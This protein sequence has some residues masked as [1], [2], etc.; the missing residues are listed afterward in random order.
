MYSTISHLYI[1]N[2]CLSL[3]YNILHNIKQETFGIELV[4]IVKYLTI[5]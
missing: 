4:F 2:V 1:F 5:Y 3:V